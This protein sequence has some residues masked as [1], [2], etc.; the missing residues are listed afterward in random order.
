M[1]TENQLKK[2]QKA[3]LIRG[4]RVTSSSNK[5]ERK[6]LFKK[7]G[8]EK[9]WIEITL[10]EWCKEKGYELVREY[11]FHP[12]R[13]W[14]FDWA[15]PG[16]KLAVEYEGLMSAKSRHTTIGGYSNDTTK[17]NEAARLGWTV[18]RFTALTYKNLKQD[19]KGI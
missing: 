8:K 4:Y 7:V 6:R 17:Y 18:L 3:G 14:K 11:Q 1:W 12:K 15:I 13:K 19:L 5:G 2:K 9:Y 16:I 10:Q